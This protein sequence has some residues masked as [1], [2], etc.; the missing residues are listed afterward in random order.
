M[1]R[2]FLSY[3]TRHKDHAMFFKKNLE[4][5]YP[6]NIDVF[7]ASDGKS[8]GPGDD[9]YTSILKN[10]RDINYFLVLLP[11]FDVS[12]WVMF[13]VGAAVIQEVNVIPLR[14]CGLNADFVP[15]PLMPKQSIDLTDEIEVSELLKRL[16]FNRKPNNDRLNNYVEKIVKHFSDLGVEDANLSIEG[17]QVPSLSKR[18]QSLSVASDIQRKI[19]FYILKNSGEK[20]LLESTIRKD[21]PVMYHDY[22]EHVKADYKEQVVCPSEYYFRLRELYHLGFLEMKKVSEFENQWTVRS[23]IK[24]SL[25]KINPSLVGKP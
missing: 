19:F 20:G 10:I 9:W 25:V 22:G 12:P 8:I 6:E 21:V 2:C 17:R 11:S 4:E 15:A 1:Q 3:P 14:Y 16:A 24:E 7:L 18:L 5:L 23:D 13:E